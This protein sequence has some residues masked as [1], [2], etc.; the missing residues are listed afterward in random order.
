ML[1]PDFFWGAERDMNAKS[2]HRRAQGQVVRVVD[3]SLAY[4]SIDEDKSTLSFV[5][6][7]LEDYRGE[8]FE[9]RQIRE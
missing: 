6:S 8:A 5:P 4:V 1:T 7:A 2:D 9:D 3:D